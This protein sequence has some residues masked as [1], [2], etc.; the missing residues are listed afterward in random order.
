MHPWPA[1]KACYNGERPDPRTPVWPY[2]SN[3]EDLVKTV[4]PHTHTHPHTHTSVAIQAQPGDLVKMVKPRIHTHTHP[5]THTQWAFPFE[6]GG[7]IEPPKVG[8]RG[9]EKGSIDTNHYFHGH[10]RRQKAKAPSPSPLK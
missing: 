9:W 10:Q 7:S 4:I 6:E 8:G 2:R 5:H 1:P 3:Q